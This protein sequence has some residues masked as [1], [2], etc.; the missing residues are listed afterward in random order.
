M[1][2]KKYITGQLKKLSWIDKATT[3]DLTLIMWINCLDELNGFVVQLF[4]N[5]ITFDSLVIQFCTLSNWCPQN[6]V[7]LKLQSL[8]VFI[9]CS[10]LIYLA[11]KCW[12]NNNKW[13]R[14]TSDMIG[15]GSVVNVH[16]HLCL[17]V[18]ACFSMF[19]IIIF[20]S[21]Y[22]YFIFKE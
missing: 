13:K 6:Q 22:K 19:Y 14:S 1:Y 21:S 5:L 7:L 15:M 10:A 11:L 16:L 8:H 12:L 20:A 4:V 9:E 18:Y 3:S 17:T 2:L